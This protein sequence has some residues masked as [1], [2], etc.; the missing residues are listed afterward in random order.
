METIK[1]K[2]FIGSIEVSLNDNCLYGKILFINDLVTYQADNID[3]IKKEFKLAVDDYVETCQTLKIAHHKSF[4]GT[5]N[6]RIGPELHQKAALYATRKNI[7][8]NTVVTSALEKH[9]EES[10]IEDGETV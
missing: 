8:I 5:F 3:K 10:L 1:Y 7:K 9:L 2:D 6:V 4:S